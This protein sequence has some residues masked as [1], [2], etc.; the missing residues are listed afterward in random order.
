MRAGI[1]AGA[2]AARVGGGDV[3]VDGVEA[4]WMA[5]VAAARRRVAT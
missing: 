5:V 2:G 4:E 3:D 1:D